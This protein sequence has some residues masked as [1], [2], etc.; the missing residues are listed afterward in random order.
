MYTKPR[1]KGV[2][3]ANARRVF[4]QTWPLLGLRVMEPAIDMPA[5]RSGRRYGLGGFLIFVP[6]PLQCLSPR[7][8]GP[9]PDIRGG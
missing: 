3:M 2:A 8:S 4:T 1:Q 7:L 6:F 5:A 9:A